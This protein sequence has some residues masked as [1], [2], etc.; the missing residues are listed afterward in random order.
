MTLPARNITRLWPLAAVLSLWAAFQ[1]T[2]R[3][4]QMID[5]TVNYK[6]AERLYAGETLYPGPE[7]DGHYEFKYPPLAAFLYLPLAALPLDTAKSVW[8]L[9]VLSASAAS[10]W[11]SLRLVRTGSASPLWTAVVPGLILSR[12]FLRE[13]ELGQVN[14]LVALLLLLSVSLFAGPSVR[15][16]SETRQWSAGAVWGLATALKVTPLIFLP[17]FLLKKKWRA[18]TAGLGVLAA[19]YVL[20]AA[21]YGFAGNGLVHKEWIAT[22]SRSTPHLFSSQDNVSLLAAAFKLTGRLPLSLWIWCLATASLG[23]VLLLFIA[24]GKN[25][26]RPE[27]LESGTMMLFI[28]LISP[29]GWDYTFL[30]SLPS[31]TLCFK[32]FHSLPRAG[33]FV[34]AANALLISLTLYD[35]LGRRLYA[36]FM[37]LSLLSLFFLVLL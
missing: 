19:G 37:S 4:S 6:A 34:L 25:V 35:L 8:A 22:L 31:L 2:G 18:L 29:L 23:L 36:G 33:R 5:F 1:L 14:S 26:P 20:P 32:H 21:F 9:I 24:R 7:V 17:Y 27:I 10:I 28:P 11:L 30:L 12:F 3:L 15:A 13:L 16:S